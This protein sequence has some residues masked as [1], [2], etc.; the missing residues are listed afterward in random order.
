MGGIFKVQGT[1]FRAVLLGEK[2][3]E[4]NKNKVLYKEKGATGRAGTSPPVRTNLTSQVF[5]MCV[6]PEVERERVF[7]C[8][9]MIFQWDLPIFSELSR[10]E[11]LQSRAEAVWSTELL[12]VSYV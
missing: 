9:A 12:A 7:S 8:S 6:S 1:Q 10:M 11:I 2:S 3:K 5:F 4:A